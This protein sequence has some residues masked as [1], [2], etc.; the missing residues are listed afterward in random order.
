MKMLYDYSEIL[1]RHNAKLTLNR[2]D[3]P[4][5]HL[6]SIEKAL[7]TTTNINFGDCSFPWIW[8]DPAYPFPD[9]VLSHELGHLEFEHYKLTKEEMDQYSFEVPFKVS[10]EAHAE[11]VS[12]LLVVR[13]NLPHDPEL[14]SRYYDSLFK[15]RVK[16][17]IS[18]DWER[19]EQTAETIC[20][21]TRRIN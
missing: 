8:V 14:S 11:E 3:L 13:L 16:Y 5:I 9:K 18:L 15:E 4:T 12:R 2:H 1:A 20:R 7:G 6:K 19:I 21:L 10:I 17:G